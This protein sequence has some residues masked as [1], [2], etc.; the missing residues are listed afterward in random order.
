MNLV[1]LLAALVDVW[2]GIFSPRAARLLPCRA[3]PLVGRTP[4]GWR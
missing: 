3:R 4:R 1:R 2:E